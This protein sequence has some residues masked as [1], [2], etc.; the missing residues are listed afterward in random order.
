MLIVEDEVTHRVKV[1][2]EVAREQEA[3]L[4]ALQAA[5]LEESEQPW[6]E[7][8]EVDLPPV[9]P[10]PDGLVGSY[11]FQRQRLGC[12]E[13]TSPATGGAGAAAHAVAVVPSGDDEDKR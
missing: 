7:A 4:E 6:W 13:G 10:L 5:L 2:V 12:P 3:A 1:L 11:G 9:P 8:M